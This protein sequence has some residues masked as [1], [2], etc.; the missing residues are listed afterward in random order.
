MGGPLFFGTGRGG[1]NQRHC[2]KRFYP[3]FVLHVLY[4]RF[5]CVAATATAVAV[6]PVVALDAAAAAVA[7]TTAGL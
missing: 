2:G 4:S 1:I 3:A 5:R 6:A 7:A